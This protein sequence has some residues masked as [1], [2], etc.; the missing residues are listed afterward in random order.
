MK[1]LVAEDS[2]TIREMVAAQLSADGYE[3]LQAVDGAE[4]LEIARSGEPDLL[5]LD[6][7]MPKLDGLEVVRALRADP[8][9][10]AV[11]IVMLT[12]QT[13]END[14]LGGITLG[15]RDYI[16]KPFS[17]QELSARVRRALQRAVS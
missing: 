7:I 3:V 11:P 14:V 15:V 1:I 8:P 10:R 12:D 5:I 4:A 17:P 16:P 13:A 2:P 9:V 6:K